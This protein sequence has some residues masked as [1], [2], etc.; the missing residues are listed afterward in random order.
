MLVSFESIYQRFIS[1]LPSTTKFRVRVTWRFNHKIISIKNTKSKFKIDKEGNLVKP[2][3][4]ICNNP[5]ET[6]E[7][8]EYDCPQLTNFRKKLART[9]GS[10][11]FT[12]EEWTLKQERGKISTNILIAKAHWVLH[13]E[14][15][16][17]DHNRNKRINQAVILKRTQRQV[18]V[19]IATYVDI[20][21]TIEEETNITTK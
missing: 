16:N 3:C 8:F 19:L 10:T 5:E 1:S 4:P 20:N 6:I 13:C 17:V 11:D 9:I 21:D 7:H 12:R 14:R 18:E 2:N 15:C